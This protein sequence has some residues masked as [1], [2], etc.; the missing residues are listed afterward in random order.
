MIKRLKSK[1]R[2][3]LRIVENMTRHQIFIKLSNQKLPLMNKNLNRIQINRVF[4][5][6][7][8][9]HLS[10]LLSNPFTIEMEHQYWTYILTCYKWKVAK[11]LTKTILTAWVHQWQCDELLDSLE[12][13]HKHK[14]IKIGGLAAFKIECSITIPIPIRMIINLKILLRTKHLIR[15]SQVNTI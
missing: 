11:F 8:E 14:Q 9:Y 7:L 3:D 1:S 2:I 4:S 13:Q 5:M 15:S 12:C 6:C 10:N